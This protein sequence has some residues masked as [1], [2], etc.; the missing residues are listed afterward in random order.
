MAENLKIR[1]AGGLFFS[2][3]F[4]MIIYPLGVD[5]WSFLDGIPG[6]TSPQACLRFVMRPPVR[7]MLEDNLEMAASDLR[8]PVS[9]GGSGVNAMFRNMFRVEYHRLIPQAAKQK[10]GNPKTFFLMFPPSHEDQHDLIV[11]FLE[12]NEATIYSSNTPGAWDYFCNFVNAGVVLVCVSS[13]S[14]ITIRFS[15]H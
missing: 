2:N 8:H 1:A 13:L 15:T 11:K 6:G 14:Q 5:T 10:D 12:A 9:D 7:H 4:M 3:H